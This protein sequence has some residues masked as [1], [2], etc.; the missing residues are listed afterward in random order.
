MSVQA[1]DLVAYG[2]A[3]MPDDDTGTNIGG[4]VSSGS[5]LI[6]MVFDD[7]TPSGNVQVVSSATGDTT[8]SVA[9]SGRDASGVLISETKTLNGQTAVAMTTNTTWERLLKAVKSATTT[10]DVAVE[11]ATAVRTG[12]AQAGTSTSITL[13]S[14]AS[15]TDDAY[16]D[17]IIR[18]TSGT[19]AGQIRKI[20]QVGSVA[21]TGSTKVA[22]VDRAWGTTPDSTSVF[23][24]SHGM[25]FEKA[26]NEVFQLR[27]PFYNSSADV[28]GGSAKTYYEKIF[29]TN[30]NSSLAL[31]AATIALQADTS[32]YVSFALE[33]SLNGTDTNGSGNNRQVAPSGYT[34]NT[35]TKN[36]ANSQNHT[37]GAGQGVWLKLALPAG[38]AAAKNTFT[39][40]ESGTTT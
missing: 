9:V 11:S 38:A 17:M 5:N 10:G 6:R 32:G 23:R 13:D 1:T 34:F 4:A 24:I 12:T 29:L 3:S 28:A 16:K 25:Y 27:R 20:S 22:T 31:T 8:Q 33:S 37:N 30:N 19:G 18:I 21:Y 2:S 35:T 26:P 7:I 39:L 14:G 36:V 40:R 15:G